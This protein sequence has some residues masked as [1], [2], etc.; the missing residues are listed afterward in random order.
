MMY[1][2]RDRLIIVAKMIAKREVLQFIISFLYLSITLVFVLYSSYIII[3]T[4]YASPESIFFELIEIL[5]PFISLI[6]IFGWGLSYFFVKIGL[7]SKAK[8]IDLLGIYI[9]I[10]LFF[11]ILINYLEKIVSIFL[12]STFLLGIL[13]F[14]PLIIFL[15]LFLHLIIINKSRNIKINHLYTMSLISIW[16]FSLLMV[17]ILLI[18]FHSHLIR[19]FSVKGVWSVPSYLPDV[20]GLHVFVDG[21]VENSTGISG[22]I[23]F[24]CVDGRVL[25]GSASVFFVREGSVFGERFVSGNVSVVFLSHKGCNVSEVFVEGG[26]FGAVY[27]VLDYSFNQ[28]RGYGRVVFQLALYRDLRD[29]LRGL[30][31]LRYYSLSLNFLSG[32]VLVLLFLSFRVENGVVRVNREVLASVVVSIVIGG[33]GAGSVLSSVGF[34]FIKYLSGLMLFEYLFLIIFSGII[35]VMF[36]IFEGEKDYNIVRKII[37]IMTLLVILWII[38]LIFFKIIYGIFIA[39][40]INALVH[41][42]L[43]FIFPYVGWVFSPLTDAWMV[44]LNAILLFYLY[45]RYYFELLEEDIGNPRYL[46]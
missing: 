3:N 15:Y 40:S 32:L 6:I 38:L 29:I 33:V 41:E 12:I 17:L 20:G 28:S 18:I 9:F 4:L 22:N 26:V 39:K 37:F 16:I 1:L 5:S 42:R 14:Y 30:E 27:R 34:S 23:S 36:L 2:G 45:F 25:N 19:V 35:S 24:V 11:F 13:I 31:S 8:F 44:S 21:L 46:F 7:I 43:G 10:I